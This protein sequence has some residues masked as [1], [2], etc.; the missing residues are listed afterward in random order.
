MLH[1]YIKKQRNYVNHGQ[2]KGL[3]MKSMKKLLKFY[4]EVLKKIDKPEKSK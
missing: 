3:G 1:A 4:I 2:G